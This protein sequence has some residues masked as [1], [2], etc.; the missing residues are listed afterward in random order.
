[1]LLLILVPL[2]WLALALF[3]VTMLRLAAAT[4]ARREAELAEWLSRKL[5]AERR[6]PSESQR[7]EEFRRELRRRLYR[8]AG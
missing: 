1:V 5:G 8:A 7:F 3:I 6:A 2:G 4:D